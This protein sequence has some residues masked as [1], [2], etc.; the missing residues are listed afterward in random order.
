M[1]PMVLYAVINC[2]SNRDEGG[3]GDIRGGTETERGGRD[4]GREIG[5]WTHSGSMQLGAT[6]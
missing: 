4:R 1:I 5:I 6:L 2:C 3:G